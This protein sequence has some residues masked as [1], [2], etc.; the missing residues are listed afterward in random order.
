MADSLRAVQINEQVWLIY[1]Q[2]YV[3][4]ELSERGQLMTEFQIQID[5]IDT[6]ATLAKARKLA[7]RGKK[8][9]LEGGWTVQLKTVME[10]NEFGVSVENAYLVITGTAPSFNGWEFVAVADFLEGVAFTRAIAGTE[11]VS[12][13]DNHCDHCGINRGRN[14]VIVVKQTDGTTKQ[15]GS[16]CVKDFLGWDFTPTALPTE[17]DFQQFGGSFAGGKIS[18]DIVP[19]FATV[20]ATVDKNGYHA[21]GVTGNHVWDYFT[22]RKLSVELLAHGTVVEPTDADC[23]KAYDLIQWGK[24]FEGDS[25]YA[26]NL[27]TAMSLGSV[28]WQT[29]GVVASAY[30]V[31]GNFLARQIEE[32]VA[33]KSEQFAPTGS[34]VELD[35][36]VLSAITIEGAYGLS[37]LYQ[38]KSGDYKFKW[39]SSSSQSIEIGKT[40][41]MKGTIKGSDEYKGV[42]ST[43]L[44]RCKVLH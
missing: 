43:Q 15:V 28:Y 12:V 31:Y 9:G 19:F 18:V 10:A 25:D 17:E 8:K 23:E 44:T 21:G 39:F 6:Q 37:V 13:D 30:K 33:Y 22:A 26:I 11:G 4:I 27:R 35:V 41:K 5:N 36:T 1:N 29:K 40:Y 3:S 38:F 24:K 34:K 2:G 42:F 7:D 16:T 32:S 20:I 14:T